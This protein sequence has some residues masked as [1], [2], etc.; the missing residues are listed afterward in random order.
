MGG[1]QRQGSEPERTCQRSIDTDEYRKGLS[2]FASGVTVITTVDQS[3]EPY[4]FSCQAFQSVSLEPPLVAFS[5]SMRSKT[6]PVIRRAGAFCVNVL[7]HDQQALSQRFSV[8]GGDKFDSV[9]WRKSPITGSPILDRV[10]AW[11][12]CEIHAEYE[13]GDHMIVV[14]R[15]ISLAVERPDAAALLFFQSSYGAMSRGCI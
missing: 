14:G 1:M 10:L 4:G 7:S 8:S 3:H 2:Y 13:A 5:P 6:W 9:P 15:V 12:E 11:L